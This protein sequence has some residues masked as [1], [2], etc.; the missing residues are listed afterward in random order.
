M[1]LALGLA[2]V[3][4]TLLGPVLAVLITRKIDDGRRARERKLEV[5]RAADGDTPSDAL[6]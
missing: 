5:F 3:F 2:V 1:N 4:A 6:V